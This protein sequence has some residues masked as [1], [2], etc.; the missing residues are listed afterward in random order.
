MSNSRCLSSAF[1]VAMIRQLAGS[2]MAS[3]SP[4]GSTPW[5]TSEIGL[6]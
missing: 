1:M 5:G 4:G 2:R 6:I 3:V